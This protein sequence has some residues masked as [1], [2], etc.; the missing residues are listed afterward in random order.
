MKV[1]DRTGENEVVLISNGEDVTRDFFSDHVLTENG[2]S[3]EVADLAECMCKALNFVNRI[4]DFE[5]LEHNSNTYLLV[6]G[7]RY[8]DV[9]DGCQKVVK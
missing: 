7:K 3:I 8:G 9:K 6:N 2:S 5:N 4:G 1:F